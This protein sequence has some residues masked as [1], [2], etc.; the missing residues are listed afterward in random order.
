M[1]I[2]KK[3]SSKALLSINNERLGKHF[4]ADSREASRVQR[5][6]ARGALI[7][8]EDDHAIYGE[9]LEQMDGEI[10]HFQQNAQ[11]KNKSNIK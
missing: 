6:Q 8:H 1:Q 10:G 2:Q 3:H 11:A 9:D 4:L 5:L 7:A